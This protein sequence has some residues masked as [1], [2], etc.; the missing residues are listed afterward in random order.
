M[1][2]LDEWLALLEETGNLTPR[3]HRICGYGHKIKDLDEFR[4][5]LDK[6]SP[7]ERIEDLIPLF[8]ADYN[9]TIS[10]SNMHKWLK[11]AG[12][13]PKKKVNYQPAKKLERAVHI[14]FLEYLQEDYPAEQILYADE[15]GMHNK[16]CYAYGWTGLDKGTLVNFLV[17]VSGVNV[18]IL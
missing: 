18:E 3:Q 9:T 10:Y 15:S 12:W 1:S 14:W 2:L 5:W 16:E 7:F 4:F 17:K 8:E 6:H 13:T 11:Q